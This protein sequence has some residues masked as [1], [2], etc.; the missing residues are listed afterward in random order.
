MEV[1]QSVRY[2]RFESE[3]RKIRLPRPQLVE[4]GSLDRG[5]DDLPSHLRDWH[6]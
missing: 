3:E 1:P 6:S 5:F 2:L 4:A